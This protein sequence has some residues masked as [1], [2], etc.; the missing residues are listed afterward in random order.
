MTDMTTDMTTWYRIDTECTAGARIVT[1]VTV[2][3]L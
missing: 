2:G 1:S 3:C